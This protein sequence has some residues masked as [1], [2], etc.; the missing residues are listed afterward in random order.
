MPQPTFSII[1][2]V[3]N[4]EK[5]LKENSA[6]YCGLKAKAAEVIF[7]DGGSTDGTVGVAR[8]YG[9][10]I[11]SKPGRGIQENAGAKVARSGY[12]LFLRVDAVVSDGA[13]GSIERVL[14]HGANGGCLTMRID[15]NGAVFRLY[16]RLVNWRE[17]AFG[18]IDGNLGM[19]IRRDLFEELAGFDRL[20]VMEDI[21]FAR[22][23][24][25]A[26]PV[27]VLT[28][29]IAVSSRKWRER[30]FLRTLFDDACAYLKLWTGQLK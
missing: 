18:V 25:D 19:F 15:D 11:V 29:E 22:K 7:V 6:Y 5:I 24:R 1:I 4:E 23:L 8:D 16:E 28:N 21:V 13:L 20:P 14:R 27:T 3:L 17:R 10:V 9:D 2:P 30:G 26:G 12:L